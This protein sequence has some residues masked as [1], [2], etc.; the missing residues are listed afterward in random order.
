[1]GFKDL[2]EARVTKKH[3]RRIGIIYL[4]WTIFGIPNEE[5]GLLQ[6]VGKY[7]SFLYWELI[8]ICLIALWIFVRYLNRNPN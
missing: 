3:L 7:H 1:M 2:N 8:G 4:I 5:S 6:G